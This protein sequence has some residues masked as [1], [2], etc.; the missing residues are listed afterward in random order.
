VHL[1]Q[2]L[3]DERWSRIKANLPIALGQDIAGQPVYGDLS[4]MPHL[5]VAGAT[6]SGK[7]VGLN[8]ILLS[9]LLKKSP[10]EV[11]LLMV[12]PKVVELA[13]F[14]GIP[15]MLLP[16]VTDMKKA[17]LG[18]RWAVDEMERRYQLF[19]DAG[20]RNILSYNGRVQKVLDGE[21]APEKLAPS[22][23]GK[24]RAQGLNGEE[25]LLPPDEGETPDAAR[26]PSGCRFHPRCPLAFDRCRT[27]EPALLDMGDGQSAACWLAEPG[28]PLPTMPTTVA[29]APLPD[30]TSASPGP[31]PS[32]AP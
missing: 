27:E 23:A 5:L 29:P 17:A 32:A 16:V 25:V 10:E 18:L 12:D 11:R 7:S 21:L 8:V 30:I 14:D 22:R 3:E 19:A 20:A 4:K 24:V 2:I 6:G 28:R 15:H 31:D 26:I 9:L 13:V 1:R